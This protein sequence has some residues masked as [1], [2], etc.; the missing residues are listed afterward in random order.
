MIH[1]ENPATEGILHEFDSVIFTLSV[2]YRY[3]IGTVLVWYRY[4]I[5]KIIYRGNW[6]K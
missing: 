5:C 6:G 4:S 1:F 2:K 3:S